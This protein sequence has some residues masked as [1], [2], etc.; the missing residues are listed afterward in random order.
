MIKKPLKTPR[1]ITVTGVALTLTAICAV[2]IAQ[3]PTQPESIFSKQKPTHVSGVNGSMDS[4]RSFNRLI[5]KFKDSASTRAGVF[6]H[7][8]AEDQVLTLSSKTKIRNPNASFLTRL[9]S[10]SDQ[11]HVAL[12]DKNMTR[13]ELFV[14]A[15]QL[16]QDPSVAYAEIDEK[17]QAYL[18]P[19]DPSYS[20]QQWH[21]QAAIT[22]VGGANLPSAWDSAT[23]VGIVV[24]VIDTGVR[25]H[26][27][28]AANL[29]PGYDFVSEDRPGVFIT[30]NDGDGR[31]SDASDPG[32]WEVAG[33]CFPGSPSRNSSWHGTH[34]AG[35]VAALTN[36]NLG[37]AGVAFGSKVL[38]VR[39]LGVCGGYTS[40]VVAGMRWAAGLNVP[41]VPNNILSNK[42]KVLNLSLGSTSACSAV[43]QDAV[44][45]VRAT[46]SVVVAATGNSGALTIGSPA[47][48]AGV[49][50]VT[51]HTQLGDNA[52]YA[53]IGPG[54]HISGPGGGRG[55]LIAGTGAGVFSTLNTGTTNPGSDSYAGYQGT[56]MA[57]PH[58]A[59]V[60]ALL[61]GLQPAISPDAIRSILTNSARPH[62]AGTHCAGRT[63]CGA[64]LLDAQRAIEQ[65]K[66]MAP[67]VSISST[68]GFRL[69]GMPVILAGSATAAPGG[70]PLFTYEWAQRSGPLVT[71]SE[72]TT[73]TATFV[74]PSL[75]GTYL[76]SLK[77]TDAVGLV[78]VSEVTV[79]TNTPPA[80]API[81]AR[82]TVLGQSLSFTAIATD[83][84][85][86]PITF[87]PFGLPLGSTLNAT[88][89]VFTW[90]NPS[91]V[92]TYNFTI[93]PND[94]M[95][96]GAAQD[97]SI[98]VSESA[99]APAPGSGGGGG[100]GSLGAWDLLGMLALSLVALTSF[101]RQSAKK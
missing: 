28:L 68:P 53:N 24:A 38:P 96:D 37:V 63:D 36:N 59:G 95:H 67:T 87:I 93:K 77:A 69:T 7:R 78:A 91:P 73:Q 47:N 81:P 4:D 19:N 33:A 39:V 1:R 51:A 92:G 5:I 10:V 8:A 79:K 58:V 86:N 82:A 40:D 94:T 13:A 35:T 101:R 20:T 6:D 25:P 76:F 84:E 65:L 34:V 11:T 18:T 85:S 45:A 70:N 71:L 27:D 100:G 23:G 66:L 41:G 88:T 16:E 29:L 64:G 57:T 2:A 22:H 74:A 43:S 72:A 54:T 83:T 31:D 44:N 60:A 48:C 52:N 46:G 97:V 17:V 49:I 32:N 98:T 56:S 89:G 42:A 21:Y 61:A 75:G 55:S 99:P 3:T 15:K 50:A 14:L 30:A 12:T 80:L 62:P 9:K 90:N 26:A